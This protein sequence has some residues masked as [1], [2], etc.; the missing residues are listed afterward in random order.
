MVQ[1]FLNNKQI[2]LPAEFSIGM[3]EKNPMFHEAGDYSF[4]F[5]IPYEP[6]AHILNFPAR[7]EKQGDNPQFSFTL[8]ID[9]IVKLTGTARGNGDMQG[10]DFPL[11]LMSGK[12][13]FLNGIKDKKLSEV[14]LGEW[15]VGSPVID[16]FNNSLDIDNTN[17]YNIPY[18]CAPVFRIKDDEEPDWL[19]KIASGE[20]ETGLQ[21]S[22]KFA[23]HFR[24]NWLLKRLIEMQG[25]VVKSN[26]LTQFND[27]LLFT[28]VHHGTAVQPEIN[29]YTPVCNAKDFVT[30][31]L[32]YQGAR[33]F[34]TPYSNDV[35]ILS[36]KGI[37]E[38][39][40]ITEMKNVVRIDP[41]IR[42]FAD[43][44]ALTF[45]GI[46]G[47]DQSNTSV[48]KLEN[49]VAT[50]DDLP[51]PGGSYL[52]YYYYVQDRDRYYQ[53][54][55]TDEVSFVYEFI[56]VGATRPATSGK[57]EESLPLKIKT[58]PMAK[59][60][61]EGT[62]SG[63]QEDY[64]YDSLIY[65]GE[66]QAFS[67]EYEEAVSDIIFITLEPDVRF[68]LPFLQGFIYRPISVNGRWRYPK[69]ETEPELYYEPETA[70]NDIRPTGTHGIYE[71]HYK[72]YL[73]WLT[74]RKPFYAY[75]R[76][77]ISDMRKIKMY[78]K[79][80]FGRIAGII[81]TMEYTI[82]Q[83]GIGMVKMKCWTV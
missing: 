57:Q 44:Y 56:E 45:E 39:N 10:D 80:R 66:F 6:N 54:Q 67:N 43:G 26:D 51:T 49:S 79:Y 42:N 2:H 61:Q 75:A 27:I 82:T 50:F 36:L 38:S 4:P 13:E 25:Y 52:N 60:E 17:N 9:G 8:I 24:I 21:S 76:M 65:D 19:N 64:L 7:I 40:E 34:H 1:L 16:E 41:V 73:A 58:L 23:R 83:N 12:S 33:I 78:K 47:D 74:T 77:S 68:Y 15:N 70:R 5:P 59:I 18:V 63:Y 53:C 72:E 32:G 29:R 46:D 37:M 3:T 55:L 81:D 11:V 71:L 48:F 22:N 14:D 20:F 28:N 69:L 31:V 30:A 62:Y 35:S